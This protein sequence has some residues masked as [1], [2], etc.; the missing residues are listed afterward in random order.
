MLHTDSEI[1]MYLELRILNTAVTAPVEKGGWNPSDKP[2]L[3]AAVYF[4]RCASPFLVLECPPSPHTQ[5]NGGKLMLLMLFL[6][7]VSRATELSL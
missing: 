5:F 2:S 4:V 7:Q 3:S 6:V 1:L